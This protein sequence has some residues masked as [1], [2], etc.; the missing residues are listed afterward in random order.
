MRLGREFDVGEV[1]VGFGS[2]FA[3]FAEFLEAEGDGAAEVVFAF[4]P[5]GAGGD[6]GGEVGRVG[7]VAC[8]GFFDDDEIFFHGEVRRVF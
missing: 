3:F 4:R 6:V 5:R 7:G 8:A 2:G 1:G